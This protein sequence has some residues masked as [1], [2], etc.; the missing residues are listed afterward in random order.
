LYFLQACI[1][2]VEHNCFTIAVLRRTPSCISDAMMRRLPLSS[3]ISGCA[4][5]LFPIVRI[6][7]EIFPAYVPST[8]A[9]VFQKVLLPLAP[10]PYAIMMNSSYTLPIAASPMTFCT[11]SI[12]SVSPQKNVSSASSQMSIPSSPGE[13]SV[14]LVIR[15]NGSCGRSPAMPSSRL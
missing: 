15:S 5:T 9:T 6:S 10:S 13:H 4:F 8:L 11:Y 14:I 2:S 7:D 1:S 12:S 3:A